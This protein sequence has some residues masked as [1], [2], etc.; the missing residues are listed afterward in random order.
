MKLQV[1]RDPL[2]EAVAWTARALPARPTAPVLAGMRLQ[3]G[4]ELTLSTFDYEVSAQSTIPGAGRRAGHRARLGQAARRDRQVAARPAG[5]PDDRR[6]QDHRQVRQRHVHPDA[7]ARRGVPDPARHAGHHGDHRRGRVRLGHPPGRHRR[8]Q[9]RHAARADR[10]PDGDQRGHADPG[11][12]RPLPA[13]RARAALDPGGARPQHRRPRPGAGA[14]RHRTADDRR[15]RGQRGARH[16][17]GRQRRHHRVR[18]RRPEDDDPAAFRR[19]PPLPDPAAER[20]LRGRRAARRAVRGRGQAGRARRRA[21]H[22]GPAHLRRGRGAARGGHRRRGPGERGDR[23]E[24][25][26]RDDADRVQPAVPARRH[27][28]GGLRHGPRLVH[29]ARPGPP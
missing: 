18:G 12:H 10:H 4:S 27:Q 25:R 8:G 26:R 3:A 21:E 20:V 7:A 15:R 19:V 13:G 11:R 29:D 6:D 22:P 16:D 17:R 24:L 5:R 1:E 2:A 14:R 23:R 28:R 9:G